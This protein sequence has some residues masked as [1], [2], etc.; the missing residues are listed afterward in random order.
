LDSNPNSSVAVSWKTAEPFVGVI[1]YATRNDYETSGEFTTTLNVPAESGSNK[2]VYH[3]LFTGLVSNTEYAYRVELKDA[4]GNTVATSAL[5]HFWSAAPALDHFTFAVYG[6]TRTFPKRHRMVIEAMEKDKPRFIVHTGDL[7]E[8]GGVDEL[9]DNNFFWAAAPLI[10]DAPLLT[11]LGN[12]EQNSPQYYA[13]FILP[14]GAGQGKKE[15]WSINYG[16]VHLVGLDTNA[17]T[18]PHGFTRMREQIE[19]LKE[20]LVKARADGAKF[21]FVFFHHPVFSSDISYYPGNTGLRTL[22]HPIFVKYGVNVVFSGHCHQYERLV[23]DG[24]N[25]IVTGGGGAPLG[26]FVAT[27]LPGSIKRASELHYMRVTIDVDTATIEMI[28]VAKV[29]GN[30]VIPLSQKPAD[31]LVIHGK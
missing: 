10:K 18:L 5:G 23:E 12:H 21:I 15:W 26:G 16:V 25:Y 27:P 3:A 19:W 11:V 9:W 13:G 22:W 7:V 31:V 14:P 6:D 29:E 2:H 4:G 17:L 24:V 20:D 30:N 28:P 8:F 1:D